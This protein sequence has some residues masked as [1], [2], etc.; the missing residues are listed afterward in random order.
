MKIIWFPGKLWMGGR[1]EEGKEKP[2][3]VHNPATG[4]SLASISTADKAQVQ[5]TVEIAVGAFERW[6]QTPPPQRA[7]YLRKI[8]QLLLKHK[9]SIANL[10]TLEHGKP[11]SQSLAE[12]EYAAGFYQWFAEEACRIEGRTIPHPDPDKKTTVNYHPIGVVGAIT[13]WNFPLA[14]PAK[15]IAAV[16]AA[17]CSVVLKPARATPLSSLATAWITSQAGLPPGVF[18][19]LIGDSRI[20]GDAL[21][22]HPAIRA[23]TITSSTETGQY[24]MAGAV[25]NIKKVCLELGGNAPFIVFDDADLEL[26]AT[27]L[28]RLKFMS[29]GQMCVTAN[30]VFVQ[31]KVY[32]KFVNLLLN[33][34][35][36]I[37][38]GNGMNPEIGLGPLIDAEAC[39]RV[40]SLVQD[41]V[42]RDAKLLYGGLPV[43]LPK[44]LKKENFY[45][46]TILTGVKDNALMAEQEIF[47]P[48]IPIYSFRDEEEVIRRGNKTVYGLAAY[49]YTEDLN[50]AERCSG[51]IEAGITGVND[52]RPL[53]PEVPFGGIKMSG[54]GWEG[55]TEGLLEFMTIRVVST[56]FRSTRVNQLS[57]NHKKRDSSGFHP[58]E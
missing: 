34:V 47:G 41:A 22:D 11:I 39:Q 28:V 32:Q 38:V 2:C 19:V 48:I 24:I 13:P 3:V 50:R 12:V 45:L 7:K 1:W 44:G 51:R 25:K 6:S 49:L 14:Q 21:L 16:L 8:T 27:D 5:E 10:I 31:Q 15:K 17:G 33:K 54:L 55:G 30:R 40:D 29:N 26:A 58:S 42:S 46:P 18:N 53:R 36:K 56:R 35:R 20:I 4:E 9:E 43:K 37:K 57:P 23:I 52:M